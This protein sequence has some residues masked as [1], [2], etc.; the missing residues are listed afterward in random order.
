MNST[1]KQNSFVFFILLMFFS[2][3]VLYSTMFFKKLMLNDITGFQYFGFSHQLEKSFGTSTPHFYNVTF[4][5]TENI[6]TREILFDTPLYKTTTDDPTDLNNYY[7]LLPATYYAQIIRTVTLDSGVQ[8]YAVKYND[9]LGYATASDFASETSSNTTALTNITIKMYSDAGTH[10]RSTPEIL[11]NN[12]I[13][14]IP[15]STNGIIFLGYIYGDT[16]SDGTN[17]LWYFVEYNSGDTTAHLGYVYSERCILSSPITKLEKPTPIT[18]APD[19]EHTTD[20]TSTADTNATSTAPTLNLSVSP[21]LKWII[22][23]LFVVPA[24]VIFV[25]LIKKPRRTVDEI[26]TVADTDFMFD[27]YPQNED[28][29]PEFSDIDPKKTRKNAKK[30]PKNLKFSSKFAPFVKFN[31]TLET[32]NELTADANSNTPQTQA[33]NF[34]NPQNVSSKNYDN[35]NSLKNNK[36]INPSFC[37]Y[38]PPNS[39]SHNEPFKTDPSSNSNVTNSTL[40]SP[41][42]TDP[43]YFI[44]KGR[45]NNSSLDSPLQLENSYLIDNNLIARNSANIGTDNAI[46]KFNYPNQNSKLSCSTTENLNN[47]NQS[48]A[49]NLHSTQTA[50]LSSANFDADATSLVNDYKEGTSME[51][52]ENKP[53][54]TQ[55]QIYD[56]VS[57]PNPLE[58]NHFEFEEDF[59]ISTTFSTALGNTP[60]EPNY[61]TKPFLTPRYKYNKHRKSHTPPK[62]RTFNQR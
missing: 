17:N 38:N 4:A 54:K 5:T 34:P 39:S 30:T 16:P 10:I 40:L 62:S 50:N 41:S 12:K 11:N 48:N 35:S 51:N 22:A 42:I 24:V 18:P 13:K 26:T 28:L 6:T 55:K 1:Q 37:F 59:D 8:G 9:F 36:T 32:S 45:A 25:L 19:T 60:I 23:I 14:I 2:A 21:T 56:E 49:T 53:N 31:T 44:K 7:F 58:N 29:I 61:G 20:Q 47:P 46:P 57:F 43:D 52:Y 27:T 3:I 15:S 33:N